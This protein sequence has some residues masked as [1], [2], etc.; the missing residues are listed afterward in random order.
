MMPG[1]EPAIIDDDPYAYS[2]AKYE[3]VLS[4]QN[5]VNIGPEDGNGV[6]TSGMT[7]C[8]ALC[9]RI[10]DEAGDI[11]RLSMIHLPGGINAAQLESDEGKQV[12]QQMLKHAP[13]GAQVEVVIAWNKQHYDEQRDYAWET[14]GGT[15]L[16]RPLFDALQSQI[17]D[18]EKNIRLTD[19][20]TFSGARHNL[21]ESAFSFSL[22]FYGEEGEFKNCHG[23]RALAQDV[24]VKYDAPPTNGSRAVYLL[25]WAMGLGDKKRWDEIQSDIRD[26]TD[27]NFDKAKTMEFEFP[28]QDPVRLKEM[29]LKARAT[30]NATLW[31]QIKDALVDDIKNS[32]NKVEAVAAHKELLQL[33][34]KKDDKGQYNGSIFCRMFQ[35]GESTH[36]R[37]VKQWDRPDNQQISSSTAATKNYK[38]D[39]RE[40]QQLLA[41]DDEVDKTEQ[42]VSKNS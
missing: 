24:H 33:H 21:D 38:Q 14:R 5:V 37:Q 19:M 3:P 32:S 7:D 10:K 17:D 12:I 34:F 28:L 30:N 4:P 42:R 31:R 25:N 1:E 39:L 18:D 2:Y 41:A 23:T 22:N 36:W 13:E 40:T 9:F 8:V 27:P 35:N 15:L 6:F 20:T 11:V 29:M 16:D 26:S